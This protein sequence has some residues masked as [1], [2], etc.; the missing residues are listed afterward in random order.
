VTAT[1]VAVPSASASA[2]LTITTPP[3]KGG[4]AMDWAT[5]SVTAALTASL[6]LRRLRH[7]A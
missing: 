5:L 1:S 6:L 3:G 2:Q 4:G 7:V